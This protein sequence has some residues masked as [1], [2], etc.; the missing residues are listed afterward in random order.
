M[1]SHETVHKP[2]RQCG[3]Y[4]QAERERGAEPALEH[5]FGQDADHELLE[6]DNKNVEK[7]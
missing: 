2:D 5:P 3:D 6:G 4:K 7:C 1:L